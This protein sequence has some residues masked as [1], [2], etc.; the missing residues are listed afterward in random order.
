MLYLQKRTKNIFKKQENSWLTFRAILGNDKNWWANHK[1]IQQITCT[2]HSVKWVQPSWSSTDT[3]A[4]ITQ[5]LNT[6][7]INAMIMHTATQLAMHLKI[8]RKTTEL[9]IKSCNVMWKPKG[10]YLY[11]RV[12]CFFRLC[13]ELKEKTGWIVTRQENLCQGAV[14]LTNRAGKFW[15]SLSTVALNA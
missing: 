3:T 8:Q 1:N 5:K 2:C 15:I 10:Q 7:S 13:V 11:I 4:K 6:C 12:W 14:L 9:N